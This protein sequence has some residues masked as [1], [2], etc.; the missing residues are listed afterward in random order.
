MLINDPGFLTNDAGLFK[1]RTM[2]YYGRWTYKFEEAARQ[3]AAGVIIVH[4]TEP[5]AY[6]WQVVRNSNSGGLSYLDAPDK[7][8]R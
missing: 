8:G 7:N 3:G 2:T 1:G 5:A 4:E 6:G